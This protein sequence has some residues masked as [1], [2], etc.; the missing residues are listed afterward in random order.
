M[1]LIH[2][3]QI[4]ICGAFFLPFGYYDWDFACV[5]QIIVHPFLAQSKYSGNVPI[6][7]VRLSFQG[8]GK[9][10]GCAARGVLGIGCVNIEMKV[11]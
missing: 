7:I 11:F 9:D 1:N 3:L 8:F 6:I 2:A 5:R 10:Q 4:G